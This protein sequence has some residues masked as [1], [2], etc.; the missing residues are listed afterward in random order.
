MGFKQRRGC[1]SLD[2][3]RLRPL[4]PFIGGFGDLVHTAS[5]GKWHQIALPAATSASGPTFYTTSPMR[6][7]LMARKRLPGYRYV[8]L[9]R[10]RPLALSHSSSSPCSTV[11]SCSSFLP[12]FAI[13]VPFGS[14]HFG[15]HRLPESSTHADSEPASR[16]YPTRSLFLFFLRTPDSR[17]PSI[18]RP[19][20]SHY[21]RGSG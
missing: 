6:Y 15:G 9:V 11:Q 20:S 12:S 4:G 1:R 21:P 5:Y 2:L 3:V 13:S 7:I 8:D 14:G 18:L 10:L 17:T 16:N 19:H